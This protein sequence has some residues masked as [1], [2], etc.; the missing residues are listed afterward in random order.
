MMQMV[1]PS[2]RAPSDGRARGTLA[3]AGGSAVHYRPLR[4]ADVPGLLGFYTDLSPYSRYLRFFAPVAVLTD[5]QVR[6]V[7]HLDGPH[8]FG[9]IARDAT[10]PDRVVA[11]AG[12]DIG[13]EA[14]C[15]EL[16]VTVAD[17]WQGRG[18]GR[19]LTWELAVAARHR[20]IRSLVASVLPENARMLRILASLGPPARRTWEGGYLRIEIRLAAVDRQYA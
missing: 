3:L 7:S 8:Q 18:L 6:R 11:V 16:A 12:C 2:G 5:E 19:A 9:L 10:A 15:A 1:Q 17:A 13:P 20:R 4:Q 14:G